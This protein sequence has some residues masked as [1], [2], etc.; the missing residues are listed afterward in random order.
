MLLNIVCYIFKIR[1]APTVVY[2]LF[3]EEPFCHGLP[4]L[5]RKNQSWSYKKIEKDGMAFFC[6]CIGRTMQCGQ[7]R[8]GPPFMK[9]K[10]RHCPLFKVCNPWKFGIWRK[11]ILEQF[12]MCLTST[13]P[14]H[15]Q[16]ILFQ[17]CW[18]SFVWTLLQNNNLMNIPINTVCSYLFSMLT[19]DSS[20]ETVQRRFTGILSVH[21][22]G[23][24]GWDSV[25]SAA[26]RRT[27]PAGNTTL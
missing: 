5:T 23:I 17:D 18:T 6:E 16:E 12:R 27:R 22:N 25:S 21:D 7:T 15:A 14:K 24:A 20:N 11:G 2:L 19:G 26:S 9:S 3:R 4:S 13:L 1:P 10:I 8:N